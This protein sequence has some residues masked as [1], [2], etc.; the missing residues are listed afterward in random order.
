MRESNTSHNICELLN[1]ASNI[2]TEGDAN[3][4]DWRRPLIHG[5]ASL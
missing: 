4:L 1:D 5:L 2:M 3:T